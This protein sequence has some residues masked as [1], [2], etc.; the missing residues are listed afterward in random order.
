MG[1]SRM[2]TLRAAVEDLEDLEALPVGDAEPLDEHVGVEAEAV[3][4][5]DRAE[6]GARLVADAVA[7]SRRRGRRSRGP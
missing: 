7:A 6:L 4:V 5:G 2:I 3:A 1:S